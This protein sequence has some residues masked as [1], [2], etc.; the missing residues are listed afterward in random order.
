MTDALW[1]AALP[2]L[3]RSLTNE[4]LPLRLLGVGAANLSRQ[5]L[6]QGQL[7]D[8][9]RKRSED[10]DQTIDAIRGRLGRG[11]I[12]RGSLLDIESSDAQRGRRRAGRK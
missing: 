2:I 12:R 1:R 3:E 9:G 6:V 7:F 10:L 5:A 4:M 8:D 11:A